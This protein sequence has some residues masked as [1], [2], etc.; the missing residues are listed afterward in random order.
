MKTKLFTSVLATMLFALVSFGQDVTTVTATNYDISDNLDLTAV[1][2]IFGESKDLADFEFRINNP[3]TQ[4]S[5]LDLNRDGRVDYLRVI[6][7]V[8]ADTHLIILQA[9]L[10]QDKYQDVA[11]I[12][13]EK[14]KRNQTV[15]VQVVGDVYLYGANYIYEPVY[16]VR[17]VIFTTFWRPYYVAYYSPWYWGYY[18]S[19]YSYWAPYPIFRYRNHVCNYVNVH[20]TYNYVSVRNSTRAVAMHNSRRSDYY[21]RQ[22]PRNSFTSRNAGYT[23]A[24]AM[25]QTR[26]NTT[27]RNNQMTATSGRNNQIS[28]VAE[29][30]NSRNVAENTRATQ[31]VRAVNSNTT[32]SRNSS[33]GSGT[34]RGSESPSSSVAR[35]TGGTVRGTEPTTNRSNS[36]GT[37]TGVVRSTNNSMS[38]STSTTRS[39][40]VSTGSANRSS[41]IGT[42][43]QPTRNSSVNSSSSSGRSSS[44]GTSSQPVRSSSSMGNSTNRS[45]GMS[46][47]SATRSAAPQ[48]RS[49]R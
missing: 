31:P 11:T 41:S 4:I 1:A 45:S 6:E 14:D 44:L 48:S 10:G 49:S 26:S 37:S 34:L 16:V 25:N 15:R 43:S 47:G 40:G 24:Y 46:G 9:V 7:A 21:A 32:T 35:G 23:N 39:S 42:S 8:E 22:N 27:G 5:N 13:V 18:P 20:N 19:Y 38:N 33:I 36:V 3:K 12:E 28:G 2:S 29:R 30:G 17:P